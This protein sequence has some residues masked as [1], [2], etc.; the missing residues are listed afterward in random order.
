MTR[1]HDAISDRHARPWIASV[2]VPMA[3]TAAALLQLWWT[4]PALIGGAWWWADR[5]WR[6]AWLVPIEAGAIGIQWAYLGV[7]AIGQ[8]PTHLM[9]VGLGWAAYPAV[10]AG[11]CLYERRQQVQAKP[12]DGY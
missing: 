4:W 10:L 3:I 5:S 8:W 7:Y 12:Y 11:I 2:A 6:W 1:A 9:L